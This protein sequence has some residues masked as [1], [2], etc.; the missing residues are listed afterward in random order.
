ML[1]NL[2]LSKGSDLDNLAVLLSKPLNV[3]F[4]VADDHGVSMDCLQTITPPPMYASGKDHL[5]GLYHSL[6]PNTNNWSILLAESMTGPF[7]PWRRIQTMVSNTGTMPFIYLDPSSGYYLLAYESMDSTGNFPRILFYSSYQDFLGGKVTY[8]TTLMKRIHTSASPNTYTKDYDDKIQNIGT[9]TI[10]TAQFIDSV[11]TIYLRFH[12]TTKSSPDGDT[13]GYGFVSFNPSKEI[14]GVYYNW[15]GYFDNDANNAIEIARQVQGGKIGQR[16]NI[17]YHNQRYYLYEAQLNSN[18]DW[19]NWRL[20]LYSVAEKRAVQ[21]SLNFNGVND[22]ANPSIAQY[23]N[24]TVV[25]VFI[26]GEAITPDTS[27]AVKPGCAVYT[28][29]LL[30]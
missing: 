14:D 7:G 26:P 1:G 3:A 9:P 22:L 16:A 13:P 17:N 19:K 15:Q 6:T 2:C 11:W 18:F 24:S 12:F 23:A 27:S 10:T 30:V 20:F 29:P 8:S 4:Q 28:L 21:L 25:T 5:L